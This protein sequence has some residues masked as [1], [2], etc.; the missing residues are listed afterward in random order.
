M[1]PMDPTSFDR[2]IAAIDAQNA[3]DPNRIVVD[4]IELPKE[5][6]Y[7]Q[8]MTHW[9]QRL[10][11]AAADELK[12]ASRA[13]HIRRWEIPRD[14]YPLT[15]AGYHQWR[16]ALAAHH[17]DVTGEILR[18]IGYRDETIARVQ[19]LLR[20]EKF[21]TD[22]QAQALEDIACLVFLENYLADFAASQDD[23]KMVTILQK[24]WTKMSPI[25]HT[26]AGELRFS[27]K[28]KELMGKAMKI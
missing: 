6:F 10:Y 14:R 11:P 15:R 22:P 13:Q 21:K 25:A 19:S 12:L 4:G 7:S 9:Q 8:Q 2:A 23:D 1:E 18:D 17:A 28:A 20:K 16:T 24:T 3:R 26:A 5:L 27:G